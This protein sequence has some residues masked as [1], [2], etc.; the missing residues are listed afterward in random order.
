MR[1]LSSVA[2]A[3]VLIAPPLLASTAFDRIAAREDTRLQAASFVS[4]TFEPQTRLLV[5]RGYGAPAI[6]DDRR[7]PPAFVV[8]E[9]DCLADAPLPPDAGYLVTHEHRE[10][11]FSRMNPSLAR[12]LDEQGQTIAAFDPYRPY[13][14]GTGVEP[15]FYRSDAFYIPFAGLDAVERGGPLVR[16]WELQPRR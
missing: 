15:V 4:E 5:C 6:N 1:A 14:Q 9:R 10:L 16:I 13:R 12:F 11:P 3:L 2:A 7:R 8:E